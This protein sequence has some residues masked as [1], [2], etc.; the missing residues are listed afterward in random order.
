MKNGI[1]VQI[2]NGV[3]L[4]NKTCLITGANSGIGLEMTR[5]LSNRE[6]NVLMACRNAYEASVRARHVCNNHQRLRVYKANLASLR[7]VKQCTDEI[8][9][10]EK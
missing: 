9:Q 3:D 8:L 5:C 4:S 2:L 10:A 6:C 1:Y 7:S